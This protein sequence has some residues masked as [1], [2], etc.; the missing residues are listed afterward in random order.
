MKLIVIY[1]IVTLGGDNIM[2]NLKYQYSV[3][4]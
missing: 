3:I 4:I 1:I 2:S